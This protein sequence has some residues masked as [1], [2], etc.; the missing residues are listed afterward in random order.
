MQG[1]LDMNQSGENR[2]TYRDAVRN[3]PRNPLAEDKKTADNTEH[4]D[5]DQSDSSE[6][7]SEDEEEAEEEGGVPGIKVDTDSFDRV[8]FT[9]SD[10][11]WKRLNKPF[12]KS[13]I[14]KLLGKTIGFQFLLRKVNQLWGRTG[15]VE[16][17]DLGNDYFLAKFDTYSDQDFALTG[18]PWIILDHYLIVRPWTTLFDPEEP[19]QKLAAWVHLPDLP[20]ELYDTKFLHTIR[21]FIGKVLRIDTNTMTQTRGKYARLC[22]EL[23]LSK[24]LLS[25]YCVHGRQRRIEYE[26]LHLIC[27]ECGVYGHDLENCKIRKERKEKEKK[28]KEQ[29]GEQGSTETNREEE[30]TTN[31][32]PKYGGWM[33]VQKNRRPRRPRSNNQQP[34]KE[35]IT[36]SR[37][38]TK[39][40][41][42]AL[43]S[44]DK[45]EEEKNDEPKEINR[46]EQTGKEDWNKAK[47]NHMLNIMETEQQEDE[48]KE[49]DLMILGSPSKPKGVP[50]KKERKG[51]EG[52]R[53]AM[54]IGSPIKHPEHQN[55]GGATKQLDAKQSPSR[56]EKPPDSGRKKVP[57]QRTQ[58]SI[59]G[60]EKGSRREIKGAAGKKFEMA[61]K[62]VYR[63]H[64]TD[65]VFLFEPRCSGLK[66]ANTIKKLGFLNKEVIKANGYA[67][68]I[69]ALWSKDVMTKCICKHDQFIQLEIEDDQHS[70]WGIIAVYANPHYQ[71]RTS[72]WPV[73]ENIA[74]NYSLPLIIA[75]DFNEI[76]STNE[77]RGGASPNIQRCTEFQNWINR[78]KLIDVVP[79][80]P[81]YTWE[82]PKRQGQEKLYKRLDRVLCSANWRTEFSD[83]S[84]KCLT[85]LHSDHHPILLS[86][87]EQ[88][89][90]TQNRPFRFEACWHGQW[91]E[92]L[93]DIRN[94][95]M[96]FYKNLF[97]KED[98]GQN[99][100][101]SQIP[102][103]AIETST[104]ESISKPCDPEEIKKAVF[105]IGGLKAP[106][107]DGYPALFYQNNWDVDQWII[108]M[109]SLS[110]MCSTE[111]DQNVVN[112]KLIDYVDES[113]QWRNFEEF[114]G[115]PEETKVKIMSMCPPNPLFGPDAPFWKHDSNGEFT[116]NNAYHVISNLNKEPRALWELI[117]KANTTQRNKMFLWKFSHEKL[118][119]RSR[120]ATWSNVSYLCPCCK[121]CRETNI[122]IIR[123]CRRSATIWNSFVNPNLRALF[124]LL[125]TKEWVEWN[126]ERKTTFCGISWSIIF[127]IGCNLLWNWRNKLCEDNSFNMPKEPQRVIL[128]HARA[129]VQAW[130][131]KEAGRAFNKGKEST[132]WIKPSQEWTKINTDGAL[133]RLTKMAGCGG[134]FRDAQGRWILGFIANIG[135]SSVIGAELWGIYHGLNTAWEKGYKKII[136]ESDSK[137]AVQRISSC[138]KDNVNEHP[139]TGQIRELI[140]KDWEV[141]LKTIPRSANGCADTLAKASLSQNQGL[142]LLNSPPSCICSLV[143]IEASDQCEI[144]DPGG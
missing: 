75:G 119:T 127:P 14:I 89:A 62:E 116:I 17:V 110:S 42:A 59:K 77:Q 58:S 35:I 118:P 40:R 139:I 74:T 101:L 65:L 67:G 32:E 55:Q 132:V 64:K 18:G 68:G 85:K 8:N 128:H 79:A 51:E 122:H 43:E 136:I 29:K 7:Q 24:P 15:E 109:S 81:F 80:G 37:I 66:A 106:G 97:S 134:I 114:R 2:A 61:F 39:S 120:L 11:E 23:D 135:I 44:K 123:D 90:S 69:W 4:Q 30:E 12:K 48:G 131:L 50:P 31:N 19:I 6:S 92:E 70:K 78:C 133:C 102:W 73:I 88:V 27:F 87:E 98:G 25:K 57:Q 5:S 107:R 137:M 141:Q 121:N 21:N 144:R 33:T 52:A 45:Q 63:I 93:H 143:S 72:I 60:A 125:P 108:G 130:M 10:R 9:L 124:Y 140:R 49:E 138:R 94:I 83:A 115:M 26:G 47:E 86:T 111:L 16:L 103:P 3:G 100:D 95:I 28:E 54:E 41:F 96:E 142:E 82:G 99:Y 91:T 112:M 56:K 1:D 117:W 71:N 22:V 20:L 36:V 84:T 126:L 13:L 38:S 46:Q 104:W 34:Q 129:Y 76:A 53:D 113:G 105:N